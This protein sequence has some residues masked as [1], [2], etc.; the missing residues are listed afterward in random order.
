M[1]FQLKVTN[2]HAGAGSGG[3]DSGSGGGGNGT[4]FSKSAESTRVFLPNGGGP[5]SLSTSS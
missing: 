1:Q 4:E 3:A 5:I 2:N